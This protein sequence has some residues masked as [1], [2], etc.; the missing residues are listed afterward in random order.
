MNW[1]KEIPFFKPALPYILYHQ[2]KYNG[3][4]YPYGL[5]EEEI[6]IEGRL[7]ACADAFDAMRTRRVYRHSLPMEKIRNEFVIYQGT[8]FDPDIAEILLSM[9]DN[10]RIEREIPFDS[11][12]NYEFYEQFLKTNIKNLLDD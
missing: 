7:I 11:S 4:G 3:G 1:L 8:Q 6:P 2:E 10:G 12:T 9:I 5:K